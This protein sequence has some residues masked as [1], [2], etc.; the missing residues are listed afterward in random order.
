MLENCTNFVLNLQLNC[1]SQSDEC[2]EYS[3]TQVI[4]KKRTLDDLDDEPQ[5]IKRIFGS[6]RLDFGLVPGCVPQSVKKLIINQSNSPLSN[7]IPWAV[8]SLELRDYYRQLLPGEIINTISKL[9]M[10]GIT[11]PLSQG[12]IPVSVKKL[13]LSYPIFHSKLLNPGDIPFSVTALELCW[14]KLQLKCGVIPNTVSKLLL[15]GYNFQLKQGDIPNS[16]I[17]LVICN[18]KQPL[19]PHVIPNSVRSLFFYRC[20]PNIFTHGCIPDSVSEI[21][22]DKFDPLPIINI[23]LTPQIIIDVKELKKKRNK[24]EH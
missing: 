18:Y 15:Q 2:D 1:G 20:K 17:Y 9:K 22:F 5:S 24:Y 4:K 19:N 13:K 21:F 8:T 16:V 7:I 6:K 3:G 10:T 23:K 14:Y 11:Q 12:I